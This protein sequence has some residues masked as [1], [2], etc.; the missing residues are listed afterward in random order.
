MVVDLL[1]D[2]ARLGAELPVSVAREIA[3]SVDLPGC[4]RGLS[5]AGRRE[6]L[7]DLFR[8]WRGL[9][10]E[11][12]GAALLTAAITAQQQRTQQSIELVWTGPESRVIPVRQTEQVLLDLIR[13]ARKRLLVVSYAVYHIPRIREALVAAIERG[14]RLQ[15]IVDVMN[16]EA[17]DGYN[18]LI[19]IGEPLLSSAEILYWPKDQRTSDADGR[20]GTLHVKCVVADGERLFISSANLTEQAFRLNMELGVFIAGARHARNVEEHFAELAAQKTLLRLR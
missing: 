16:P 4:L 5:P 9:P 10:A 17:I 14:V 20:R 1:A 19:A 8:R 3:E 13:C 7:L 2:A 12:F 6:P 18:P 11:A 15:M